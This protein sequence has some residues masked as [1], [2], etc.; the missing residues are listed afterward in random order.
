MLVDEHS[1]HH[2]VTSEHSE[3]PGTVTS[4]VQSDFTVDIALDSDG[5]VT[6]S[7]SFTGDGTL[8]SVTRPDD[9]PMPVHLSFAK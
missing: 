4:D 9:D 5:V 3:Y 1:P 2:Q 8:K 7:V 6:Q